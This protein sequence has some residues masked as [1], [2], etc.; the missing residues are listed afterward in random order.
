VKNEADTPT[1]ELFRTIQDYLNAFVRVDAGGRAA[2]FTVPGVILDG[3]P[4]HLCPGPFA[5]EDVLAE[6]GHFGSGDYFIAIGEPPY[7]EGAEDSAQ[8]APASASLEIGGRK[9]RKTGVL[10][11][12]AIRKTDRGWRIAAWAWAKRARED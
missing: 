7:N 11:N 10:F 8:A 6:D 4:P 9:V 2:C 5:A 12:V 3:M 1:L